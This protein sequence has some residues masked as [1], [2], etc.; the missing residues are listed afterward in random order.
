MNNTELTD[1]SKVCEAYNVS[2]RTLR[3]YEEE[4]LIQST[5]EAGSDRRKYTKEQLFEL[6]EVLTLRAIG[7]TVKEIKSYLAGNASLKEVINLRKAEIE[8]SILK[9]YEEI[10]MLSGTLSLLDEGCDIL[11][12][13]E[14]PR[15]A[16][17][18]ELIFLAGNCA[19]CIA[20]NDFEGMYAYL[21]HRI[22]EYMPI[23]SFRV[24]WK[25][26]VE[27]LGD[28]EKIGNTFADEEDDSIIYQQMVFEKMIV[29]LKFVFVEKTVQGLWCNY[30]EK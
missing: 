21:G 27:G 10:K 29:Q 8:A 16:S 2:S 6:R 25:D 22:K 17:N 4:G 28:F 19:R 1:I 30:V 5:R 20:N 11:H 7:V 12:N 23:E 13:D 26:T 24:I 3:F 9:K 18:E 15:K 14:K